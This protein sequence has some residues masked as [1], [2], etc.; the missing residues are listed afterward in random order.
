MTL[1]F[2]TIFVCVTLIS[3]SATGIVLKYLRKK[4]I[5]DHP[6][7]RS[8]HSIATPRGGG[9]GIL[10]A[11][12][13]SLFLVQYFATTPLDAYLPV[14]L[15]TF[16]LGLLSWLDDLKDLGAALR[17]LIQIG[18]VSLCLFFLPIPENGY[19]GGFLPPILEK[20]LL[21]LGWVWFI[22]LFNFMDGIDGISGIETI[23][24]SLGVVLVSLMI[25]LPETYTQTGLVLAGGALGFLRWNWHKAQVFMGDVGSVPLGFLL[26]WVLILLAAEGL[27]IT[28]IILALY[29]LMDATITLGKRVLRGEKAWQ[30]HK[31]HFYQK[32]TQAG[33]AHDLVV[34]KIAL[35]NII[36]LGCAGLSLF[37]SPF[38]ALILALLAV[39]ACL[40]HFASAFRSK[41]LNSD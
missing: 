19:L 20:I 16:A 7:E 37:I 22:N 10:I 6:N 21:G 32:A 38:V 40:I 35:T 34:K 27:V 41:Q 2:I 17:F 9:I 36:L 15:C 8:S 13:P 30:A 29:Y 4:A 23:S 3:L 1:H 26:G 12:L 31:E 28:A 11:V 39:L 14:L 18:C 33:M 25:P 5:L 24:I